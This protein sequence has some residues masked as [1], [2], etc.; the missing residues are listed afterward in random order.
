VF[1]P[2]GD[3]GVH[4]LETSAN[5]FERNMVDTFFFKVPG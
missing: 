3:T 4:K 2:A 1:G 5:N